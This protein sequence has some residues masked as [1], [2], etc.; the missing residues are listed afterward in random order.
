M[1]GR[2]LEAHLSG[3]SIM[4]YDPE[5]QFVLD[6]ADTD[7]YGASGCEQ[8]APLPD[9]ELLDAY[10][11]AV[12]AAAE[13]VSPAVLHLQAGRPGGR[14]GPAA[15]GSG[16]VFTA[17]GFAL[18]NSHVVHGA[19]RI[20]ATFND[21]RRTYAD[22]IGEDSDT[23]LAVLRL[24]AGVPGWAPLGDSKALRPGQLVVAIGNPLGFACTVTAGVVSALG[25][26]LRSRSGRLIDDVLQTDAALNPGN[27]GGPLVTACG[28]IVGINTAVIHGAQ[29]LCF[30]V[31]S[32]TASVVA[33]QILR[34]GRVRRG[35][36]GIAGETIHLPRRMM[37]HH[38]LSREGA[39]RIAGLQ[40]EGPAVHAGLREGDVIV[41]L[42]DQ[43]VAG[44]DDLYRLLTGD[45][46]EIP[47][48]IG[49][50]R[51]GGRLSIDVIPRERR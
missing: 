46:I 2:P 28:D 49:I 19:S 12:I 25:R 39:V 10:S 22:L 26:S 27:S 32:A 16:V 37:H 8:A 48:R 35:A 18:T 6:D 47:C 7:Q 41:A 11:R 42:D 24:H 5:L 1:F 51:D 14:P 40:S 50:L 29:G 38:A 4:S 45:R 30:A 15:T 31:S 9:A 17:D 23:D 33:S 3:K 13:A 34:F 21:G 36:L 43:P 44:I 20:E